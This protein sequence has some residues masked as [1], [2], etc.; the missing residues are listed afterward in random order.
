MAE[1]KEL[2]KF[3]DFFD[4][5]GLDR[6]ILDELGVIIKKS[7]YVFAASLELKNNMEL[8]STDFFSIGTPLGEIKKDFIPTPEFI[9]FLSKHSAR[10]VIVDDKSEW[11]FLCKKDIFKKGLKKS[12]LKKNQGRVFVQNRLNENLGMAKFVR[13]G[14]VALKHLVDKGAYIRKEV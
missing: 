14:N 6:P 12:F 2:R 4:D 13:E 5:F 7:R 3:Y 10:K 8:F 11:M 1:N 9:D